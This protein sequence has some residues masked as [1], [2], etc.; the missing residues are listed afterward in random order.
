M[1]TNFPNCYTQLKDT[2]LEA[3]KTN[4]HVLLYTFNG[5]GC[6]YLLEQISQNE[7]GFVYLKDGDSKVVGDYFFADF[8]S[9]EECLNFYQQLGKDQKALFVVQNGLDYSSPLI[10]DLKAHCYYRI[11]FGTRSHQDSIVLMQEFGIKNSDTISNQIFTES[12]GIARLIKHFSINHLA[13]RDLNLGLEDTLKDIVDSIYGYNPVDLASLGLIDDHG[14]HISNQIASIL[15]FKINLKVNFDLSFEEDGQLATNTLSPIEAKILVKLV[16]N[17][18]VVSKED[19]SEI[20]WGEG[21]YDEFSDQA[22][23]KTMRR[24]N[25]KLK[26]YTIVTIPKVGFKIERNEK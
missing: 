13:G 5:S 12:G 2:V 20:K 3:K 15:S 18:G 24:L 21:K 23:N 14:H 16:N 9:L 4:S 25:Q 17:N 10:S 1:D 19:V 8:T 7:N 22:I 26:V 11:P 6:S